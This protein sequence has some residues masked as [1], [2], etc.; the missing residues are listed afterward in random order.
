MEVQVYTPT[1]P[2]DNDLGSCAPQTFWPSR[3]AW[4]LFFKPL[5]ANPLDPNTSME[6]T[7]KKQ[8]QVSLPLAQTVRRSPLFR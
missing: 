4:R 1:G 8:W 3:W 6:E 2:L 5:L 7:S